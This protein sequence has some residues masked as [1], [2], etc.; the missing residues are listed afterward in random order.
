VLVAVGA[1]CATFG[2][3]RAGDA[4]TADETGGDGGPGEGGVVDAAAP[5]AIY[6]FAEEGGTTVG[7]AVEPALDLVIEDDGAVAWTE[8]GLAITAPTRLRSTA[9]AAKIVGAAIAT[10]EISVEAWIQPSVLSQSGPARIVSM[11]RSGSSRNFTLGQ[12]GTQWIGRVSTTAQDGMGG[13]EL[14]TGTDVVDGS[15]AH[16][17]LR[18]SREAVAE[19]WVN[20]TLYDKRELAGTLASWVPTYRLTMANEDDTER[21]WL[22]EILHVTIWARALTDHEIGAS[23]AVGPP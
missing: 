6:R 3:D 21:P 14:R 17:V 18:H 15:L 2:E 10:G 13:N 1:A 22:G 20:G 11:G 9:P 19:L 4:G 8:R 23:Y 7:D 16:L 12:E 5:V